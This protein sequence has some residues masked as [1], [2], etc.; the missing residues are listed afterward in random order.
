[1]QLFDDAHGA[2]IFRSP[3]GAASAW[4]TTVGDG[5]I[6]S[7]YLE[8]GRQTYS[9]PLEIRVGIQ[10]FCPQ[11]IRSNGKTVRKCV[12][13]TY[14]HTQTRVNTRENGGM[15]VVQRHFVFEVRHMDMSPSTDLSGN[16][17]RFP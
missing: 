10:R 7:T 13:S 5:L 8:L 1:M 17:T 11:Y 6:T 16:S 2:V 15:V 14:I 4:Y 12:K 3:E 9:C